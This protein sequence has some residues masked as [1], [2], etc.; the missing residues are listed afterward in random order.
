[1]LTPDQIR[2]GTQST[3]DTFY[4]IP[5][6]WERAS[7]VKSL[8]S[9][10]LFVMVSK[11]Y[12]QMYANT[13]I[14]TDSARASR[15]DPMGALAGAPVPQAFCDLTDAGSAGAQLGVRHWALGVGYGALGA[16]RPHS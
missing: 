10:L 15:S 6:I 14:A 8:R 3:W 5:A 2:R 16:Q 7:I 9:R 12:R 13:G 4:S 11:L 1:M